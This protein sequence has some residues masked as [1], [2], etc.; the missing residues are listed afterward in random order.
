MPVVNLTMKDGR[1]LKFY[2]EKDLQQDLDRLKKLVFEGEDEDAVV[3]V[4]GRERSGKSLLAQQIAAY[5]DPKFDKDAICFDMNSF[6]K[7]VTNN[8]KRAVILDESIAVFHGT[9]QLEKSTQFMDELLAMS[10]QQNLFVILVVPFFFELTKRAAIGRS[11]VL[12]H[13]FREA[14][15]RGHY[16][17]YDYRTKRKLF[18][19]G[20]RLFEYHVKGV[21]PTYHGEFGNYYTVDEKT[22]RF[23]KN[24]AFMDFIKK[25]LANIVQLKVATQW[26]R[27]ARLIEYKW[28][29]DHKLLKPTAL[30]T[31]ANA[32]GIGDTT[33]GERLKLAESDVKRNNL[34]KMFSIYW[35]TRGLSPNLQHPKDASSISGV[36]DEDGK[37]SEGSGEDN[38]DKDTIVKVEGHASGTVDSS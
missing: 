17:V 34:G 27:M 16:R 11:E 28:L 19:L 21:N 5:A 22:Y 25:N 8:H 26:V 3:V 32:A 7:F 38:K 14:Y 29:R 13:V 24:K 33:F 35:P 31:R 36:V 6:V 1:P 2:L 12:I 30:I 20:K 18:F 9:R 23:D 10:G 37:A 15:E 4:D